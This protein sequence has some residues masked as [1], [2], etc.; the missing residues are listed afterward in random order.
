MEAAE[1]LSER[2]VRSAL[3]QCL[4]DPG[5]YVTEMLQAR[6]KDREDCQAASDAVAKLE[7]VIRQIA[8]ESPRSFG[9]LERLRPSN[10]GSLATALV[11]IDGRLRELIVH[12]AVDCAELQ[13]ASPFD[14]LQIDPK[15]MVITGIIRDPD[16]R[17]HSEGEIVEFRGYW[18][19][20]KGLVTVARA[21]RNEDIVV[22]APDLRQHEL[23]P[24]SRL[25]LHRHRP[26][27]ATNIA[28]AERTDGKYELPI[29]NLAT[30]FADLAA[31]DSV[32]EPIIKN[33][34]LTVVNTEIAAAFDLKP[35]TGVLFHSAKPGMGKTTVTVALARFLAELGKIKGFDVSAF[36]VKPNEF[37]CV[38]HGEDA[39]NVR[40]FFA[41]LRAQ[42]KR[43]G[44]RQIILAI[45]DE[46]DSLGTRNGRGDH[47]GLVSTAQNDVVQAMLA[48]MDGVQ[49]LVD[50]GAMPN[51]VLFLGLTNRLDLVDPALKR[52]NRFGGC[53]VEMPDYDMDDA[54]GILW[55][56]A[57]KSNLP[58][59]IEGV[60]RT[61]VEETIVRS[62]ILRPA[63]AQ[64]FPTPILY[65][66]TDGQR[67]TDVTVG[68]ILAGANYMN[69][70][71]RAKSAAA[72]RRLCRFGIPAITVEDVA[73]GLW[74]ESQTVAGQ[75]VLDRRMLIQYLRLQTPIARVELI[76]E[77][78]LV[79]K[80][81]VP[82]HR[83]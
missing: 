40:E 9:Y 7:A 82:S 8:E 25:V 29:E 47:G 46:I 60:V 78:E 51:H 63:L 22:L 31:L 18:D 3:Q 17:P 5:T 20:D 12:P 37:K 71:N 38:W 10:N 23:A 35:L 33:V 67:R 73:G 48:E 52:P 11:E 76:P 21:G 72:M 16:Q 69:A 66:T 14:L 27:W 42:L 1:G 2:E 64:V 53:V 34:L 70:I 54:E 62:R 75:L 57:R 32:V 36:N 81:R 49:Q 41:I 45:F 44:R 68:Q 30:S 61:D 74:E 59:F 43:S 50:N 79:F 80:A 15:G 83:P 26:H 13:C 58:W 55:V 24:G 28:S 77:S 19:R 6:K 65:Y 56:H 39:R 4:A